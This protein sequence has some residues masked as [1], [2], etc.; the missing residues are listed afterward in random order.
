MPNNKLA[1][2]RRSDDSYTR[3][4]NQPRLTFRDAS[5]ADTSE[6]QDLRL[7]YHTANP[8]R[9]LI[10]VITD[11][12]KQLSPY[13][14]RLR[15]IPEPKAP[16]PSAPLE[17]TSR[18]TRVPRTRAP[19]AKQSSEQV[20]NSTHPT[21]PPKGNTVPVAVPFQYIYR[22]TNAPASPAIQKFITSRPELVSYVKS[23]LS[24]FVAVP[25]HIERKG[26]YVMSRQ[27]KSA[28]S[29]MPKRSGALSNVFRGTNTSSTRNAPAAIS[30]RMNVVNKPRI[31]ASSKGIVVRHKEYMSNILSAATT[32]SFNA[33]GLTLNPGKI[34]A[35]PW[36]ST[37]A[38]NFDKYRIL[39][40]TISLVTNQPT[41]TAG[42][43]GVG[44][45][46]DST[47]P[48]P[49]DRTDFFSLTHHAECAAWDS[50]DFKIPLQGGVRFVNSHTA[51]DSKLIDY[52]QVIIMADQIV[53]TASTPVN[54]G[55]VIIDYAVELIDP[56]QAI[57]LTYGLT[58]KNVSSF[59]G[60]TATGP[61]IGEMVS[62]TSTTVMEHK[63]PI[64]YYLLTVSLFDGGGG[65]PGFAWDSTSGTLGVF[66]GA[67]NTTVHN[68]IAI[69][70][71]LKDDTIL[72]ATFSGV[73]IANLEGIDFNITRISPSVYT[74]ALS[75]TWS[76]N[77]PN[78]L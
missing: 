27:G 67:S 68:N 6:D 73:T 52:G 77:F 61:S 54:L 18:P 64:G 32:L 78:T 58:G 25:S 2:R 60:L 74:K 35:F 45:D 17:P 63:L 36:L 40:C 55:D 33:I 14:N 34:Q 30:R 12:G 11:V 5:S 31:T 26:T 4:I 50:L 21:V 49:D 44:F 28:L 72:R 10:K 29:N 41:T 19:K 38:G 56:Q 46:Y 1:L 7:E 22:P 57:M 65:T 23:G 9:D 59:A 42:R 37:I 3:T 43:V 62:T 76:A 75:N 8:T 47:D 70:H 39:S 13:V 51:T 53:T 48:V 71:T 69:I 16:T 15:S 24:D 66:N 20:G